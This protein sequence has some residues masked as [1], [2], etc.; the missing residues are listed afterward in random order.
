MFESFW[1]QFI[2]LIIGSALAASGFIISQKP[3]V[4]IIYE[5]L[6]PF[7]GFFGIYLLIIGIIQFHSTVGQWGKFIDL[8]GFWGFFMTIAILVEILIGYILF[9]GLLF[10]VGN[11]ENS[12]K[13]VYLKMLKLQNPIGLLGF[14]IAIMMLIWKFTWTPGF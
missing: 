12:E 11:E 9:Y 3:E 6:N 8:F 5:K 13:Q 7:K 14:L 4:G 1:L 10:K 2:V